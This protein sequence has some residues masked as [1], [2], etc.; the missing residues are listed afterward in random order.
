MVENDSAVKKYRFP[1][2]A[3][4]KYYHAR[5]AGIP[6]YDVLVE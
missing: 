5:R 6:D 4:V 3:Y 1:K 2:D